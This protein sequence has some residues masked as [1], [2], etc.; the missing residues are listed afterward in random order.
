MNEWTNEQGVQG[1]ICHRE[2]SVEWNNLFRWVKRGTCYK[3]H[4]KNLS[5]NFG[6]IYLL[7]IVSFHLI[8]SWAFNVKIVFCFY[9]SF[10][11]TFVPECSG[12]PPYGK[13]SEGETLKQWW[14]MLGEQLPGIFYAC[15]YLAGLNSI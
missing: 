11:Y 4:H 1:N 6:F 3:V 10:S 15:V 13:L 2:N 7:M 9:F 8:P 5:P 12:L 14:L